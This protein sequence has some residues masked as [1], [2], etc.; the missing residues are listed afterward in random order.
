MFMCCNDDDNDEYYDYYNNY[1]N[2][3]GV[4]K[5]LKVLP[6]CPFN[7]HPTFIHNMALWV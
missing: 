5:A 6:N 3:K 4:F 7:N 1:W 2:D